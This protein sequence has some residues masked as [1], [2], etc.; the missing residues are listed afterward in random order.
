MFDVKTS[1]QNKRKPDDWITYFQLPSSPE[2]NQPD[3]HVC[4][5]VHPSRSAPPMQAAVSAIKI[6][7]CSKLEHEP[8]LNDSCLLGAK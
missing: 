4:K 6:F 3:C 8:S 5:F 7:M 2:A 1:L